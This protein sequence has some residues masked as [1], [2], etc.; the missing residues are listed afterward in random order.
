MAV[1][2]SPWARA[3]TTA[4][5]VCLLSETHNAAAVAAC[6]SYRV[7]SKKASHYQEA[8]LNCFKNRR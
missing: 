3:C 2:Q 5:S 1:D 7:T 6:G 8:S 4:Y